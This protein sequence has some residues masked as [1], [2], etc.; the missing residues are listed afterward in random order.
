MN[1][2]KHLLTTA[3]IA[4]TVTTFAQTTVT[5]ITSSD[6]TNTTSSTKS[7]KRTYRVRSGPSFYIGFNNFG[8]SVPAGYDLSPVGSR[9]V[10]LGWQTRIPLAMNGSTKLRLITGPEVAWNNFMFENRNTLVERNGQLTIEQADTDLRRSKLV[11]AQLNLPLMMNVSFRSGLSLS[12]GAYVGMRLDSYTKVKPEGGSA[13][14][15]HGSY[16]LN[17][18]RWGLTTELGYRGSTK[19][20][21]RYE[22]NSPFRTG[23]G[24]DASV[25][26][27][28][29]KI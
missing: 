29:L 21:L 17:P 28:G 7:E 8:G 20:F 3:L 19:L 18:F 27:V 11:T 24:P 26:S 14:R 2:F 9:F 16:Q 12:A 13:V 23:Q 15:K 6:S 4:T 1:M 10:A 5:V 22:P 25:W